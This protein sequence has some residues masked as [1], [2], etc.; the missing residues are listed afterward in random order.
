M[1]SLNRWTV[2]TKKKKTKSEKHQEKELAEKK[3]IE[4]YRRYRATKS[5]YDGVWPSTYENNFPENYRMEFEHKPFR[6]D[7]LPKDLKFHIFKLIV[8]M[9]DIVHRRVYMFEKISLRWYY[10]IRNINIQVDLWAPADF[11]AVSDMLERM[12]CPATKATVSKLVLSTIEKDL[13]PT[14]GQDESMIAYTGLFLRKFR[15]ET[16]KNLPVPTVEDMKNMDTDFGRIMS[17]A[18]GQSEATV[19]FIYDLLIDFK[20]KIDENL[21]PFPLNEVEHYC[22]EDLCKSYA[23]GIV[24]ENFALWCIEQNWF[25]ITTNIVSAMINAKFSSHAIN[26]VLTMVLNSPAHRKRFQDRSHRKITLVSYL[27]NGSTDEE[28]K[29]NMVSNHILCV[30]PTFYI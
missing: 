21:V 12:A 19:K 27:A 15:S 11:H 23:K 17:D 18:I 25:P 3:E 4:E 1:S 7:K 5:E 26:K 22:V 14:P 10:W 13:P 24:S 16:W 30:T 20:T 9:Y 2:L 29:Y 6:Y 8:K 28:F